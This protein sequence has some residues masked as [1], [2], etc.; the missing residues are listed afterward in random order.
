MD[1]R[2]QPVPADPDACIALAKAGVDVALT[3]CLTVVLS[4]TS[5]R[6]GEALA[7]LLERAR[8]AQNGSPPVPPTKA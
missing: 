1:E 5:K 7:R 6:G 2:R 3:G 8:R 4:D